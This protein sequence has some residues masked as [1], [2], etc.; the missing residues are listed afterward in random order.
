MAYFCSVGLY[1]YICG[2][3]K[4]WRVLCTRELAIPHAA[5][6][7]VCVALFLLHW[8]NLYNVNA[9]LLLR[10]SIYRFP[11]SPF[12]SQPRRTRNSPKSEAAPCIFIILI[13]VYSCFVCV[14]LCVCHTSALSSLCCI[15]G[16]N[17]CMYFFSSCVHCPLIFGVE[18]DLLTSIRYDKMLKDAEY[19]QRWYRPHNKRLFKLLGRPM[20]W[21]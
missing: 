9:F 10:L 8:I 18:S 6:A 5:N 2:F 3:L 11:S 1:T 14:F 13:A 17:A 21:A 19:F 7:V 20:P 4:R 15:E 16:G 12:H